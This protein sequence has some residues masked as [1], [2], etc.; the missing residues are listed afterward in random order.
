MGAPPPPG[1]MA[2]IAARAAMMTTLRTV[3]LTFIQTA[4]AVR[5]RSARG[6][7]GARSSA[8]GAGACGAGSG[9]VPS[10]RSAANRYPTPK[11]VWT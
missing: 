4:Y 1:R 9:T 2:T 10:T 7:A 6:G 11:W 3:G 5:Q 8:A